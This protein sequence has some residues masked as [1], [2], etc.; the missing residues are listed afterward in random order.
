MKVLPAILCFSLACLGP[1]LAQQSAPAPSGSSAKGTFAECRKMAQ[2]Q[3]LQ[4]E[5]RQKFVRECTKDVVA[6]CLE[7]AKQQKLSGDA[8]KSFL[9]TCTGRPAA[10]AK[11]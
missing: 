7:K 10:P 4:K 8:R 3:K 6:D 2:E 11:G 1:S 5:Q 9:R